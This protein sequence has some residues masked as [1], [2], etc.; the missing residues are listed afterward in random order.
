MPE[1]EIWQL[2]EPPLSLS[3]QEVHVWRVFLDQAPERLASWFDL[4]SHDEQVRANRFHFESDRARF[5][6]GRGRLREILSYYLEEAPEQVQ[7][8]YGERGKP[9]LATP[10]ASP[11]RFNLAHSQGLALCAVMRD[12][13][14]GIDLEQIRP[15]PKAKKLAIRYFSA[16]EVTR[17]QSLSPL[18]QPGAFFQYWT[19]KEAYVKAIGTGLAHSLQQIEVHW[20]QG[21]P[22]LVP[23]LNQW[24]LHCFVPAP[25]F[26]A[27]LV[28]TGKIQRLQY[29]AE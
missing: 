11:F 16:A 27:A 7:F 5:I 3:P 26:V 1:E 14:V 15:M 28:V 12:Y 18:A 21:K 6:V 25:G 10:S 4:L 9:S 2:P 20:A 19:C 23:N 24:A 22:D 17:L 13:E 8:C 29:F